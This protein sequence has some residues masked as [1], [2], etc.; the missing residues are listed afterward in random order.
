[1]NERN[2][3]TAGQF[4]LNLLKAALYLL[5]FIGSQILVTMVITVAVTV[6]AMVNGGAADEAALME[7]VMA[8]TNEITL[9]SNGIALLVVVIFF[10][11][12]RKNLFIEVG[13]TK[14]R[15]AMIGAAAFAAP[16]LYTVIILIMNRLPEVWMESYV[17][18]SSA[19]MGTTGVL[20]FLATVIA[21]PVAE[22]VILRGLALSRL[23]RVMPGWL[24][25]VVVSLLFGLCHGQLV[26]MV[27]AFVLGMF[28]GWLTLCAR[29]IW[30]SLAA[31]MVFNAIGYSASYWSEGAIPIILA[32]LAVVSAV[33]LTVFHRGVG[34]LFRRAT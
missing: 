13:L 20:P 1:M 26:W 21:A 23:G 4:F 19:L 17:E 29:S 27:Y 33:G 10:L 12:R 14:T 34:A 8:Y 25:V 30:P 28:F 9:I 11:I 2:N 18:A 15:P 24:A 16:L 3:V 32:V 7:Q 31:H 6:F 22:E 5:L